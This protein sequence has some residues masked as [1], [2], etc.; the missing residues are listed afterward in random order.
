MNLVAAS[1]WL[2]IM[3]LALIGAPDFVSDSDSD[4]EGWLGLAWP[5]LAWPQPQCAALTCDSSSVVR[6]WSAHHT[7]N[8]KWLVYSH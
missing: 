5:G 3:T 7:I 4:S 8:V 1:V 2:A 6:S